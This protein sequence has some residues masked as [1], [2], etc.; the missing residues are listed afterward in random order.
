MCDH[1]DI[2]MIMT[3]GGAATGS[4]AM[5]GTIITITTTG[6]PGGGTDMG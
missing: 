5:S 1:F 2:A 6:S 4:A 3:A